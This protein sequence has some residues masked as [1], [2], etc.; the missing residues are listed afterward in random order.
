[1]G[2]P[3]R[4]ATAHLSI[5]ARSQQRGSESKCLAA[6]KIQHANASSKGKGTA[7]FLESY[8][9]PLRFAF[10]VLSTSLARTCFCSS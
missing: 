10:L 3:A 5:Q 6:V 8:L 1:M 7:S 4:L 2:G 9:Y